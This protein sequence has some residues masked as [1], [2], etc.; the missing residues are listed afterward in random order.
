VATSGSNFP[1]RSRRFG[2][3]EMLRD[4]L[5]TAIEE[6]QFLLAVIGLVSTIV[7]LKFSAQELI[8]LIVKV[9]DSL[10]RAYVL[11]YLAAAVLAVLCFLRSRT[12]RPP[13]TE[14]RH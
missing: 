6:G 5:V 7:V 2:Y 8:A 3:A 4:V 10:E 11:G 9:L 12:R 14:Q 13:K 1:E